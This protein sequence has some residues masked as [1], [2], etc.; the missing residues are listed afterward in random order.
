MFMAYR[1][2][3][4]VGTLLLLAAVASAIWADHETE[5]DIAHSRLP[6][7]AFADRLIRLHYSCIGGLLIVFA[8]G[9]LL[10]LLRR[11]GMLRD[12]RGKTLLVFLMASAVLVLTLMV[13]LGRFLDSRLSTTPS[14]EVFLGP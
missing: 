10:V 1:Y 14:E 8:S 2:H 9:T 5:V 6:R 12:T 4:V 11:M 13:P 3:L 7:L